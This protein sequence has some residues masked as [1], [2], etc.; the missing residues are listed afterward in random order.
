MLFAL[1]SRRWHL[2]VACLIASVCAFAAV[3]SAHAD[4]SRDITLQLRWMH[5][6]QSAG[7]YAAVEKGFYAEE[8]LNVRLQQITP[9]TPRSP[10]AQVLSGAAQFGVSNA[11]GLLGS[12]LEGSDVMVLAPIFQHSPSVLL[13]AGN[14]AVQ[15]SDLARSPRP[16]QMQGG[17]E[18]LELQAM[19]LS[20]GITMDKLNIIYEGP[21]LQ[22]LLRGELAAINAYISNEL[23]EMENRQEPYTVLH[24]QTFGMDFYG[25][26]LFTTRDMV[27]K[28]PKIVAAFR[29]ASL[30][31]WEYALTHRDEIIDIILRKYNTQKKTR[32]E[33]IGESEILF[34][35]IRPDFVRVGY[36]NT[37]RWHHIADTL[38]KY[39]AVS[40]VRDL[41]DFLYQAPDE[42]LQWVRWVAGVVGILAA[43]LAMRTLLL[44]NAN[45]R[46]KKEIRAREDAEQTL[47]I[48]LRDLQRFSN[49]I[50][51]HIMLIR[52]SLDERIMSVT[53]ALLQKM[54]H[55][56]SDVLSKNLTQL[57][58]THST[59]MQ[60]LRDALHM[61]SF[62]R[63]E[64]RVL[65]RDG[66][67]FWADVSIHP[68]F[69]QN[70]EP[71]EMAVFF[72]DATARKRVEELSRT[73][74]LTGLLNRRTFLEEAERLIGVT[75]SPWVCIAMIDADFFKRINDTWG[76]LAGDRVLQAI[77]H[78]M[79][80]LQRE[81]A[82]IVGR[83]GGEEFMAMFACADPLEP[84]AILQTFMQRIRAIRVPCCEDSHI[85]VTVSIGL[86]AMPR[87]SAT[88]EALLHQADQAL[89]YAKLS[90][91][92]CMCFGH[93]LQ[94]EQQRR[95]PEG[96]NAPQ[97]FGAS[98]DV[99]AQFNP[100]ACDHG[101]TLHFDSHGWGSGAATRA[102]DGSDQARP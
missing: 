22:G 20:E 69:N 46:L 2:G 64:A 51:E 30:R 39:N 16:I 85:S 23:L 77:A 84:S 6:F 24:P 25:D 12:Y 59:N 40:N 49:I 102:A 101:T 52:T 62:W 10:I 60:A 94:I 61:R 66:A 14:R 86:E 34:G 93:D 4:T 91:R 56:E 48:A 57:F 79:Q 45:R 5:Q 83:F 74:G 47:N 55:A 35:L 67:P 29:K 19:F 31:G 21:H 50:D 99:P 80:T 78:E 82:A 65:R 41:K 28:H 73:D 18:D 44:M 90:G 27:K 53:S 92:D 8:G 11:G 33:L 26:V 71:I 98:S 63:G 87:G 97:V 42:E 68:T 96:E 43:I 38:A 1:F 89:Y 9:S 32:Q 70:G 17:L 81:G 76:H 95:M 15:L 7:Y 3:P 58:D 72:M 37:E 100:N 88:L 36:S 75:P 54:N 13:V